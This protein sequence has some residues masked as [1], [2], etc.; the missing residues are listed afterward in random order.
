MPYVNK[1]YDPD[2]FIALFDFTRMIVSH[3]RGWYM[4]L[5]RRFE[6]HPAVFDALR[7]ARPY[8]WHQLVL[9]YP[10]RSETDPHR[11]AYTR[12]ERAG[13]EDRQTVTTVG[14]YL[15]RHFPG[16]GAH[17]VRD[18]AALYSTPSE[19]KILD[20]VE[21]F[22]HAVNNG[23]NS[24]MCWREERGVLCQD[25][26]RRHPYHTYA[27]EFGWRMAV[28][29]E[30]GRIDGRALLMH[31]DDGAGGGDKYFVRSFKRGEGYSYTDEALEAWLKK[32]GYHH[33]SGWGG[34]Y[35]AYIPLGNRD[36]LA[37][38]IDGE[39][40]HV[41]IERRDGRLVLC[42][43]DSGEYECDNTDGTASSNNYETCECCGDS[44]DPE[45][46]SWAGYNED[47]HVCDSCLGDNYVY[48]YGRNG[49]QY[50]FHQ[51]NAVYVESQSEY[52]HTDY[53][54][55]NR[56][57][58]TYDGDFEHQD[59]CVFIDSCGEYYLAYDGRVVCDHAGE[60]QLLDECE[61]L[62]NGE[63]ALEHE[64]FVCAASGK[65]YLTDDVDPIEIDGETYHPDYAPETEETDTETGE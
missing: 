2:D 39:E 9:E 36:F 4:S 44:F 42:I 63:W 11:L 5:R 18:I 21:Q 20:D 43:N 45:D 23:P 32:Q 64:T 60:W 50:Y 61:Q 35:L 65:R 33:Y 57:V 26:V 27:P 52:Y 59:K 12:D 17:E 51:D 28:R 19:F 22:V 40:Q 29:L 41:D 34:A 58:C 16:L 38:Y 24:C 8:D 10:H 55:H 15:T 6:I 48:G 54:D 46:M 30:G 14:K 47:I 31:E 25:N 13:V 3:R 37:P 56:I 7:L 49:R 1:P 53:L 62:E